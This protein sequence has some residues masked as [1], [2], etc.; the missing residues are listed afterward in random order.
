MSIDKKGN[1][2]DISVNHL[3]EEW[4]A[5]PRRYL[6]E[7]EGLAEA[8]RDYAEAKAAVDVVSAE[9]EIA[10]RKNPKKFGLDDEKKPTESAIRIVVT[11][12]ERVKKAI[13]RMNESRY[14]MDLHQAAVDALEHRPSALKDLVNLWQLGYLMTS[15]GPPGPPNQK[16]GVSR[17]EVS[18]KRKNN[19]D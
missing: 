4:L 19:E 14:Q 12:D 17:E 3:D 16:L 5:Q 11:V 15:K 8:K 2:I 10:V 18:G 1:Y 13:S 9:V 6:Q 7:S